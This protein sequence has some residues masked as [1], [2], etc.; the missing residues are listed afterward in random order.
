MMAPN[1]NQGANDL[2][3]VKLFK[4]MTTMKKENN[5]MERENRQLKDKLND[6]YFL[7]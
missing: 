6:L 4:R 2:A 7:N 3:S 5:D 1:P